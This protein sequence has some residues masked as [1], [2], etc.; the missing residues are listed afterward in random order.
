MLP[1]DHVEGQGL[2][3]GGQLG[4]VYIARDP[5]R[6]IEYEL[7]LTRRS[8]DQVTVANSIVQALERV[9]LTAEQQVLAAKILDADQGFPSELQGNF[10]RMLYFSAVTITTVGYGDVI[11]LTGAARFFAAFEATLGIILLGLFINSLA[12]AATEKEGSGADR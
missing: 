5:Q 4:T 3:G 9:A 8:E 6:P 7:I 2:Q 10:G 11:P 12:F 1:S